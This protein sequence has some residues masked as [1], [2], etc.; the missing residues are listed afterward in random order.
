MRKQRGER[1]IEQNKNEFEKA[2]ISGYHEVGYKGQGVTIAVMDDRG[3]PRDADNIECPLGHHDDIIKHSSNVCGVLRRVVP[4]ARII[5]LN[6]FKYHQESIDYIIEH[7]EEIDIVNCS[8]HTPSRDLERLNDLN[9]IVVCAS[10]NEGSDSSC[11]PAKADWTISCSAVREKTGK[12]TSYSNGGADYAA[13]TD[14]Y[15][16]NT[17]GMPLMFNGTSCSSPVLSGM[18]GLCMSRFGKMSKRFTRMLLNANCID[19]P[20]TDKDGVGIFRLP[21][22]AMPDIDGHWANMPVQVI[23][24]L[25]IM[26]GYP[27]GKFKPN[28]QVTRAELA[29]TLYRLLKMEGLI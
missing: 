14:I 5:S 25:G 24:A 27:G 11:Y 16:Y 23:S 28:Q 21:S 26:E 3:H 17:K 1:M 13:Y 7:E 18:I 19:I 20:D 8:F 2:G 9:I 15:T 29:T 6:Y 4:D 12:V 10:G 22:L